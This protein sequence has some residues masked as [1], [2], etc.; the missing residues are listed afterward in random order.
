M[1]E[2]EFSTLAHSLLKHG[3]IEPIIVYDGKIVDGHNRYKLCQKHGIPFQTKEMYF[4]NE[5]E[6]MVW[7]ADNQLGRRNISIFA[8]SE[9]A[10]KMKP[11]YEELA[12]RRMLSGKSIEL[13]P[14]V[15]GPQGTGK[16]RDQLGKKYNIGGKTIERVATILE[17]G[18]PE[19]IQAA[20]SGNK[21]IRP[22]Y[23][24]IVR[25][26]SRERREQE[27]KNKPLPEGE[28]DVIYADP[29]WRY[30]FE[31]SANR[32]IENHYPTMSLEDICNLKVPSAKNAV[33]LLWATAPKLQEALA[34]M[35]SWGFEYKTN[36]VWDKQKI[37][38]GYWF[39]GQHELLLVGTKGNFSPPDPDRRVPSVISELRGVH[40]KKPFKIYELI[41][42]MFPKRRYVELF[43][44]EGCNEDWSFWGNEV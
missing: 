23:N 34:V 29:P 4:D 37:G 2:E 38:L 42:S 27:Y 8:R 32:D 36:A 14:V 26:Q 21:G 25:E 19:Q 9:L 13:D 35:K 7:I 33:L 17:K 31:E 10:L 44:R 28:F 11:V 22:I 12:K 41:E 20:K 39:R 30:D 40:S 5:L 43:A 15:P 6:A 3:C 1:S 24:E 18:T 16:S